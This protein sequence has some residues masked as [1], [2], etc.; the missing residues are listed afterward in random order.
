M[1]NSYYNRSEFRAIRPNSKSK[2]DKINL[3]DWCLNI[4]EHNRTNSAPEN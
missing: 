1:M 2:Y 3:P 4:A